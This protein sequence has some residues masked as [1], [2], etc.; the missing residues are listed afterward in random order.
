MSAISFFMEIRKI[1]HKMLTDI[2][3]KWLMNFSI[4]PW[5]ND[6]FCRLLLGNLL[7]NFAIFLSGTDKRISRYFMK[8][9]W[10]NLFISYPQLIG[11]FCDIFLEPIIKHFFFLRT[12]WQ[13]LFCFF[14][15]WSTNFALFLNPWSISKFCVFSLYWLKNV[16]VFSINLDLEK[17]RDIFS[18]VDRQISWWWIDKFR[19]FF[20]HN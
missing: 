6:E 10:R 5:S 12:N 9:H 19:V 8:I 15:C 18:T 2:Q 17:N 7:S 4:L 16:V 13:K 20:T 11:Q 1:F 14:L 3:K